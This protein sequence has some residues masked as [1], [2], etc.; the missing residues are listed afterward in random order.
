MAMRHVQIQRHSSGAWLNHLK[1]GS[2][3]AL[4]DL[5]F[6]D[7]G[8]HADEEAGV[9]HHGFDRGKLQGMLDICGFADVHFSTAHPVVKEKMGIFDISGERH[10]KPGCIY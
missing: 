4:A 7:G 1:S 10:E 6:E 8:F 5:E 2:K 9:F 3:V